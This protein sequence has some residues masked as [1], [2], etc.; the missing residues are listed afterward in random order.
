MDCFLDQRKYME[1][2]K[3]EIGRGGITHLLRTFVLFSPTTHPPS[4]YLQFLACRLAPF[5]LIIHCSSQE[6]INKEN[7]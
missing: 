6:P 2:K 3:K 4:F 1:K 7:G 5:S